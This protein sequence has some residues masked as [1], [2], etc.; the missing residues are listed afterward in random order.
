VR[1]L[2]STVQEQMALDQSY[3]LLGIPDLSSFDQEKLSI[4]GIVAGD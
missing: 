4:D 2:K 1:F 3:F